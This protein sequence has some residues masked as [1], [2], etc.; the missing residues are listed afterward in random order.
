MFTDGHG[1]LLAAW[2]ECYIIRDE[3]SW[4]D[5]VRRTR[6]QASVIMMAAF[7]TFWIKLFNKNTPP[8]DIEMNDDSA[9][10]APDPGHQ[11]V[12]DPLLPTQLTSKPLGLN[13][14]FSTLLS[15]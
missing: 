12:T 14:P 3:I 1:C 13:D 10:T 2:V 5:M 7:K 4:N 15:F 9:A 11:A 8:A 6:P